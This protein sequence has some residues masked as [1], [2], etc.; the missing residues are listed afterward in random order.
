MP[1][2][3][4]RTYVLPYGQTAFRS[5]RYLLRSTIVRAS[6]SSGNAR[7]F[8]LRSSH[9]TFSGRCFYGHLSVRPLKG[10]TVYAR[11]AYA[12]DRISRISKGFFIPHIFFS[13]VNSV[14]REEGRIYRASLSLSRFP[15]D[16][17]HAR[18]CRYFWKQTFLVRKTNADATLRE[19]C[20]APVFI[21]RY[22]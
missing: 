8:R 22:N 10:P 16:F 18:W 3:P 20:C 2:R 15:F 17:S 19:K 1:A 6:R 21:L 11:Y 5:T 9:A 4:S 13:Y 12:R 7:T 14:E